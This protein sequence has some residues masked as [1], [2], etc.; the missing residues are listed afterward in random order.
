MLWCALYS[1][2]IFSIFLAQSHPTNDNY[3]AEIT[4]RN[5]QHIYM[6]SDEGRCAVYKHKINNPHV[7]RLMARLKRGEPPTT[8]RARA[9]YFFSP[10]RI[11]TTST[12]LRAAPRTVSRV[13][14]GYGMC[15][16]REYLV[17]ECARGRGDSCICGFRS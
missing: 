5:S 15:A 16:P 3:A 7:A 1:R 6:Q 13:A 4:A 17:A 12:T 8:T 14:R 2:A 10:N 9:Q 11:R